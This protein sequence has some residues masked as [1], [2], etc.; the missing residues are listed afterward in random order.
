M[1][2]GPSCSVACGIVPDQGLKP[3]PLRWQVDS[4]PPRHQGGPH[5][6]FKK[7]EKARK[8]LEISGRQCGHVSQ[9]TGGA[10]QWT[11]G[12]EPSKLKVQNVQRP[13]GR[14]C[15]PSQGMGR[16]TRCAEGAGSEPSQRVAPQLR[17]PV[18]SGSVL[19]FLQEHVCPALSRAPTRGWFWWSSHR[20]FGER[21]PRV[22][23]VRRCS[24]Q[25][26]STV[27]RGLGEHLLMLFLQ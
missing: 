2:H 17:W 21:K 5:R 13:W 25:G 11:A 27:R 9:Q 15:S 24:G 22:A 18:V 20:L 10:A 14:R 16:G 3:C 12:E 6:N 23:C 26:T 4:S 8:G 7:K 19:C 1:A